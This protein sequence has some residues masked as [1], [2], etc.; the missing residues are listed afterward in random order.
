MAGPVRW[1]RASR[2]L[3]EA[4]RE[5]RTRQTPMERRLWEQLRT[6]RLDG[7]GFRPQQPIGPYIVD[8]YCSAAK[9]V[10]EVDGGIHEEQVEYDRER[11]I[12]L[13]AHGLCVLRF[14][15]EAVLR[16]LESV[17]AAIRSVTATS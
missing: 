11:D 8:F 10:I 3:L 15:N 7:L 5:L 17:L 2:P 9:L 6:G 13:A 1:R 14:A 16:D 12:Y 4:A